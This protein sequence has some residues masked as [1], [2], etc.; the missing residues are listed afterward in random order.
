[1]TVRPDAPE[2]L[3][4]IAVNLERDVLGQA[5]FPLLVPAPP[6]VMD[7]AL[8]RPEPIGLDL[9]GHA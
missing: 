2:I 5:D 8:F 7:A 3:Q 6:K 9:G 1:M 4:G